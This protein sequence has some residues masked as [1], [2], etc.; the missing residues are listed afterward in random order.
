MFRN[1]Y[2]TLQLPGQTPKFFQ[3]TKAGTMGSA[4]TQVL[5]DVYRKKWGK[6]LVEQQ[7]KEKELYRKNEQHTY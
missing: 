1:S 3:K 4:C 2:F 6:S 5:A 7:E